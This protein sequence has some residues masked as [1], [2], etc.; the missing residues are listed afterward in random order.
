M[1]RSGHGMRP[2]PS[3]DRGP[4]RVLVRDRLPANRTDTVTQRVGG[5]FRPPLASGGDRADCGHDRWN[6]DREQD[7]QKDYGD[8]EHAC[9][10]L[11]PPRRIG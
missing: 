7:D 9:I 6:E 1:T 8:R 4:V 5:P 2:H 3:G 11:S 10:Q